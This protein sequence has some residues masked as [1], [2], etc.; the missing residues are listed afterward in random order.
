LPPV[1]RELAE[2]PRGLCLVT[3]P[4]GAGKATTLAAMIDHIN[5]TRPVHILTIED[6]IEVLHPD[7]MA[8][9]NQLEVGIDTET[10]HTAMAPQCARTPT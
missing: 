1:T 7:R 4:T 8:T 10:F 3:G 2:S 6:P 5:S 9:V